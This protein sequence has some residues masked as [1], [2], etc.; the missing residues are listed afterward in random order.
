V[1]VLSF[2]PLGSG[3]DFSGNLPNNFLPVA[4]PV[5]QG[6]LGRGS[7]TVYSGNAGGGITA[8]GLKDD[9]LLDALKQH[10]ST[11][12]PKEGAYSFLGPRVRIAEDQTLDAA[13]RSKREAQTPGGRS[14]ADIGIIDT[15]FAFWNPSFGNTLP[16]FSGMGF[17]SL[18]KEDPLSVLDENEIAQVAQLAR[19]HGDA[20]VHR[21]LA[22]DHDECIWAGQDGQSLLSPDSFSHGTAMAALAGKYGGKGT[23][24]FGIEL[25]SIAVTDPSG[26]VLQGILAAAIQRMVQ[27]IDPEGVGDRRI[28][29]AIPFAF[30][31]G[32]HGQKNL[33]TDQFSEAVV[34]LSSQ[35]GIEIVVPMGNHGEDQA[36]AVAVL[37]HD[38][39]DALR[40][41]LMPDDYSSSTVELVFEANTQGLMLTSPS[42]TK[43]FIEFST[44]VHKLNRDHQVIGA[45]WTRDIGNG[46]RRARLSF[47]QTAGGDGI[48][49]DAGLWTLEFA[50][51]GRVEAW[52]LRDDFQL[53]GPEV[54]PRRQ[55]RFEDPY[56][57]PFKPQD[58]HE[59][60][61]DH[62]LSTVRRDGSGSVLAS[63]AIY[64]GAES[65]DNATPSI[66]AVSARWAVNAKGGMSPYSGRLQGVPSDAV[67]VDTPRPGGGHLTIANGTHR[68]FKFS[69]TSAAAAIKAG[70]K[71]SFVS[72]KPDLSEII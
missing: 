52:V 44:G 24:L 13:R 31:G 42:G 4:L 45:I 8:R 9:K 46:L 1:S 51:E 69:G 58:I 49:C 68:K 40:L 63:S 33:I 62:A 53:R 17:F 11:A 43:A 41:R 70:E 34:A 19:E 27:M 65:A 5:V 56:Y 66:T 55:A 23:R 18:G 38:K 7:F 3:E 32:P 2:V 16:A 59:L 60:A 15:G 12:M 47:A 50:G 30:L 22:Q 57:P 26:D 14:A 21:K 25:P 39:L 28:V 54:L 48:I 71:A 37:G 72:A 6:A 10:Q 35:L 67:L 20:A 29:I 64:A 61:Q 36:H